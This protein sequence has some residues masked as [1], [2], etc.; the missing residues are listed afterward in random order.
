MTKAKQRYLSNKK[1]IFRKKIYILVGASASGK[2]TVE[3]KLI[4]NGFVERVVSH[5]S[6]AIR[7]T[8]KEGIDYYFSSVKDCLNQK[9]VLEIHI[10]PEWVYAVS[11]KELFSHRGQSDLIYS[12]INVE[13]AEDMFNYI[14]DNNLNIEPVLV[15]FDIDT[16][17]RIKL[18]KARGETDDD[19]S[20]RLSREDTIESFSINPNFILTDIF[21]AYEDILIEGEF[22]VPKCK[23]NR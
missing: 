2:T 22:D 5:T 7:E 3:N 20:L 17:Q 8:E 21:S 4:E 6:R 19:I 16:N 10:T 9:N 12:C 23:V 11:Q 1:R 13:P 14:K 15:F 18:L